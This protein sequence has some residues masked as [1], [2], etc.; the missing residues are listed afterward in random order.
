MIFF[1]M[2]NFWICLL[3]LMTFLSCSRKALKTGT[4]SSDC[5]L[6][7][8]S[9][10]QL[11]LKPDSTFCYIFAYNEEEVIGT[12]EYKVDTLFLFSEKFYEIRAPLQ[13]KIKNSSLTRIEAYKVR[14]RS[15]WLID[16]VGVTNNC[17]LKL[18]K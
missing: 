2:N 4:Y 1:S 9:D 14:R 15:L 16:S 12:W 3:L 8:K 7:D 6:Y 11:H 10:V 5:I 18:L 13:P 17:S